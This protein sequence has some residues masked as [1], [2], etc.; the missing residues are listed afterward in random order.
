MAE[1]ISRKYAILVSTATFI[2]GVIL[3]ATAITSAGSSAIL[4]GRFITG[5][6]CAVSVGSEVMLT[7][8]RYG[9]WFTVHD[10][11]DVQRRMCRCIL[12]HSDVGDL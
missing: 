4:G 1:I 10:R 12:L 9:R 7:G 5:K 11:T 8:H 3:Q 6:S 2:I